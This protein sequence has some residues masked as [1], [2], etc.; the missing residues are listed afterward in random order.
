MS[1][2][3]DHVT[4]THAFSVKMVYP[5][6]FIS[7]FHLFNVATVGCGFVHTAHKEEEEK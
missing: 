2:L 5:N 1:T 7:M 6:I 4:L 3:L